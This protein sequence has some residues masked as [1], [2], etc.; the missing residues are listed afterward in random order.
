MAGVD[1]LQ[2]SFDTTRVVREGIKNADK[3]DDKNLK[4]NNQQQTLKTDIK[5]KEG[6][7]DNFLGVD[8]VKSKLEQ[9]V[10]DK[11]NKN[12]LGSLDKDKVKS[13]LV[14]AGFENNPKLA[15]AVASLQKGNVDQAAKLLVDGISKQDEK[16]TKGV[17]EQI[18][19]QK[20]NE[21]KKEDNVVEKESKLFQ[22]AVEEA[23][24]VDQIED[25]KKKSTAGSNF[26][27]RLKENLKA[28]LAAGGAETK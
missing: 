18:T 6:N 4:L 14:N 24:S 8:L 15:D 28:V 22:P 27:D 3:I 1:K 21:V 10:G 9:I 19:E 12:L 26:A 23:G 13:A 7:K 20:D 17:G 16:N 11:D 25:Q 2:A 5:P